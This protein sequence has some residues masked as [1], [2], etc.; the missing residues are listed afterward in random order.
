MVIAGVGRVVDHFADGAF[1]G[2][3]WQRVSVFIGGHPPS[4]SAAGLL[5][6]L[7]FLPKEAQSKTSIRYS[8]RCVRLTVG[9]RT[10]I[11]T[12]GL[13]NL[14][15][16]PLVPPPGRNPSDDDSDT[17]GIIVQPVNESGTS[18]NG[19]RKR[20]DTRVDNR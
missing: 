14:F 4:L 15:P 2:P 20:H 9:T 1:V 18:I 6:R 12:S 5:Q 17:F 10:C 8:A 16:L 3:G 7:A 11:L 19:R 13:K